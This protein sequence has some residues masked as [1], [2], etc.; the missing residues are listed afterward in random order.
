[1]SEMKGTKVSL[2]ALEKKVEDWF[3]DGSIN[4]Q[5]KA[6]IMC[7]PGIAIVCFSF[8]PR[9]Y[10][11]IEKTKGSFSKDNFKFIPCEKELI[12]SLDK[13]YSLIK[14]LL[15]EAVSNWWLLF[16]SVFLAFTCFV[17][18]ETLVTGIAGALIAG[19]AIFTSIFV[20]FTTNQEKFIK[21]RLIVSGSLFKYLLNDKY[22]SWLG[23]IS[24][25]F[26]IVGLALRLV[27]EETFTIM[28]YQIFKS[29]A[30]VNTKNWIGAALIA[31]GAAF[32]FICLLSLPQYYISRSIYTSIGD[33]WKRYAE[34]W[35]ESIEAKGKTSP[36][37]K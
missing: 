19:A 12:G 10:Y 26:S 15:K 23:I 36:F 13:K 24:V 31:I 22:L 28:E 17:G 29:V 1:M 7:L 11:M 34:K 32:L 25:F 18:G 14:F 3:K 27:H 8:K 35:F 5:E 6:L 4:P 9:E 33:A 37:D 21:L 20:L 2:N 30:L 16:I